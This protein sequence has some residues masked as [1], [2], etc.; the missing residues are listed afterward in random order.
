MR[1]FK[2]SVLFVLVLLMIFSLAVS[3]ENTTP[4]TSFKVFFDGVEI[5]FP[6]EKPYSASADERYLYTPLRAISEAVGFDVEWDGETKTATIKKNETVATFTVGGS[7]FV[8]GEEKAAMVNFPLKNGRVF[9]S[10]YGICHALDCTVRWDDINR[11]LYFCSNEKN[12]NGIPFTQGSIANNDNVNEAYSQFYS[13]AEK[14]FIFP[15]IQEHIIPQGI[16]YRKDKNQFIVSGCFNGKVKNM[17]SAIAIVDAETGKM[18]AYY[19]LLQPGGTNHHGHMGGIAVSDKDI[20]FEN[21]KKIQRISLETIDNTPS[22]SFLKVEENIILTLG[23]SIGNDWLEISDGYLWVG[24]FWATGV[25]KFTRLKITDEHPFLIRGYKLDASQP[26]GLSAEYKVEGNEWYDYVPEI[27]YLVDE[28]KIQGMTKVGNHIITASSL[29]DY[30][31]Q[32]QVYDISKAVDEDK[33]ITLKEGIEIPVLHLNL[34][35]KIATMPYIEEITECDG[36]L[37]AVY[38]SPSI[39]FRKSTTLYPTD[40]VWKIDIE[41]LVAPSSK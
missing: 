31:S 38:E 29:W 17:N 27:L 28:D 4:S 35:K 1:I 34:E 18:T 13:M 3:A 6:D 16:C 8:N 7:M 37:Y 21:G 23:Q 39:K 22:G 2:K 9:V 33:K 20:Y 14:A 32:I 36:K 19:Q 30:D 12:E 41:K 40:S 15:G 25:E 11:I 5:N 24:N 10:Q 26:N